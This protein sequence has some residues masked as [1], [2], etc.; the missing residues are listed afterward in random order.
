MS[1]QLTCK[2]FWCTN[3]V[4]FRNHKHYFEQQLIHKFIKKYSHN[5][6]YLNVNEFYRL[7]LP[8]NRYEAL[9]SS[10]RYREFEGPCK[11]IAV[12]LLL[13]DVSKL[14]KTEIQ[15]LKFFIE[16][17]NECMKHALQNGTTLWRLIDKQYQN[18]I[19]YEQ[20]KIY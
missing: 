20:Y 9:S 5:N 3:L 18:M 1:M 2:Y 6:L 4:I 15:T 14:I 17:K 8:R 13:E 10:L 19:N 16:K 7:L 12:E 11:K